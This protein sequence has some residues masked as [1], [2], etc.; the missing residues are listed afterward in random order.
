MGCCPSAAVSGDSL[1]PDAIF[2]VRDDHASTFQQVRL[3]RDLH[4][5]AGGTLW[6]EFIYEDVLEEV[7]KAF[8]SSSTE[9][10]DEALAAVLRSIEHNGWSVEFNESLVN[11]LSV[12]RKYRMNFHA[13]DD[14]EWSKDAF[15]AKYGST[16][17]GMRYLANRASHLDDHE[18]ATSR[19]CDK[20]VQTRS[21]QP[22][23]I[24]VLGGAEHGPALIE[25]MKARINVEVR[26]MY[27]DFRQER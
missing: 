18:G 13:L 24:V 23:P 8:A 10:D 20:I 19:W 9:D 14:P 12:A 25:F 6:L 22:G 11:L 5:A 26:F 16:L 17:G 4:K 7:R 27:A 15:I 21:Q 3:A 2:Y 1:A